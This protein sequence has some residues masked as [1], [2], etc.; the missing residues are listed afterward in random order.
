MTSALH[1]RIRQHRRRWLWEWCWKPHRAR[2]SAPEEGQTVCSTV[3]GDFVAV[4]TLVVNMR[5]RT[6]ELWRFS[7]AEARK[8][9]ILLKLRGMGTHHGC[10]RNG[11]HQG[12]V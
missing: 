2:G 10:E 12:H 7:Q 5:P 4:L 6:R 9:T 11:S 1:Q 3:R 8:I